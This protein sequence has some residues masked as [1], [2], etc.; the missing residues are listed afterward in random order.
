VDTPLTFNYSE[1]NNYFDCDSFPYPVWTGSSG[2]GG[3]GGGG[4]SSHSSDSDDENQNITDAETD[5]ETSDGPDEEPGPEQEDKGFIGKVKDKIADWFDD[6]NE[7]GDES[8]LKAK[9]G[10]WFGSQDWESVK[11]WAVHGGIA[12]LILAALWFFW[13]TILKI[14]A[15]IFKVL[16]VVAAPLAK[17]LLAGLLML[18]TFALTPIGWIVIGAIGLVGYIAYK[19]YFG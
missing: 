11:T 7:S 12:L 8:G 1:P 15:F 17:I 18:G 10:E 6:D 14:V 4:G 19:L 3:G 5:P 9:I 13:K 16:W 2:S